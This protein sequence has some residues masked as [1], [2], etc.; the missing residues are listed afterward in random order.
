MEIRDLTTNEKRWLAKLKNLR[1]S[2]PETIAIRQSN[3]TGHLEVYD[4]ESRKRF[5]GLPVIFGFVEQ[6][7]GDILDGT[8]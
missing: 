3:E 4:L 5:I 7:C 8:I 1:K 6:E 2:Q